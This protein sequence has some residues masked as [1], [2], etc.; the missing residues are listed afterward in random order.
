MKYT[1]KVTKLRQEKRLLRLVFA[2]KEYEPASSLIDD[3]AVRF[4]SFFTDQIN[5]VITGKV[6]H[7]TTGGDYIDVVITPQKTIITDVCGEE[8]GNPNYTCSVDTKKLARAI[9]WWNDLV[10]EWKRTGE[11]EDIDGFTGD[12][13]L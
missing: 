12:L 5:N 11:K 2:D 9:N 7:C 1:V 10:R 3:E 4:S 8:A 6:A 13:D